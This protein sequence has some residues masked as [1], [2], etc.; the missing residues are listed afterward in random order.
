MIGDSVNIAL[1]SGPAYRVPGEA[2]S[3]IALPC[4]LAHL[5]APSTPGSRPARGMTAWASGSNAP[6]ASGVD[7]RRT[8]S[9]VCS[10]S[11][12]SILA[13]RHDGRPERGDV[14]GLRH[15]IAAG[16]PPGYRGRS[17]GARI[18]SLMVGL[19]SSRATGDEV[20]IEHRQ[21]GQR[22]QLRLQ[23]DRGLRSDRCRR[24]DNRAPPR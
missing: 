12:A 17:R 9:L 1:H 20:E 18:S 4:G 5:G 15:R 21:F 19:R 8:I 6:S 22:R 10:I 14:G 11:G 3:G 24:R 16:S 23:A 13:D 7:A 2:E